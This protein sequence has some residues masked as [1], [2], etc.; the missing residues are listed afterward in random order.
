LDPRQRRH[1]ER[2]GSR[3]LSRFRLNTVDQRMF[4]CLTIPGR[5]VGNRRESTSFLLMSDFRNTTFRRCLIQN[6]VAQVNRAVHA[7]LASGLILSSVSELQQ[8]GRR[9]ST[10]AKRIERDVNKAR[11]LGIHP[12][13]PRSAYTLS[14]GDGIIVSL[15]GPV[16][17]VRAEI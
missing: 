7:D 9:L 11:G 4:A 16:D 6:P 12:L 1:V 3:A 5:F 8:R 15:S 13:V 17:D 14:I 2:T 10:Q